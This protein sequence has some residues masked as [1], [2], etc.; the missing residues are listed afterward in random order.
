MID[1]TELSAMIFAAGLTRE[2]FDRR[3]ADLLPALQLTRA[4]G[5]PIDPTTALAGWAQIA[6]DLGLEP[7]RAL[8]RATCPDT[9]DACMAAYVAGFGP[10]QGYLALS[11]PF[12]SV[13]PEDAFLATPRGAR[14]L[15]GPAPLPGDDRRLSGIRRIDACLADTLTA[16]RP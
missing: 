9:A 13:M 4:R 2:K 5:E 16:P 1:A 11:Q 15:L 8:C 14:L 12:V 6:E 7:L 3:L 10:P